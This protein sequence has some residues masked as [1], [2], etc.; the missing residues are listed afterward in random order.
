MRSSTTKLSGLYPLGIAAML[1]AA[2]L[3]ACSDQQPLAVTRAPVAGAPSHTIQAFDCAAS[4]TAR[5]VSCTP[6]GAGNG[7]AIIIGDQNTNIRLTSSNVSYDTQSET[8]QFDVTVQNLM[9]EAIG[10]PDG[11]VADSDGIQVFFNSGPTGVGTG[12]VTVANADGTGTFTATNQPFF[13]YHEILAKNQVSAAHP[14]QLTVPSTVTS[15]SFTLFVETDVQYLL[16]INEMLVNP[17][18]TI[19]DASG[20]WVELYNAG[21]LKVDLKGLVITDSLASG[22]R[23][24]HLIN[25]SVVVQ[26]GA[27]VVL[28]RTAN[29]TSNGGVP[30]DYVYTLNGFPNSLGAFKV[31]RVYGTDTLTVDRT[32]YASASTSAQNGISRELKNP[33]FDNS[34]MDGSNWGDATVIAVYGPGGRGTPKAQNSVFTP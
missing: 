15:F 8:F 28:G 21:T 24:Y 34:N 29:T 22:R 2:V 32:Q 4:T 31:A 19:T 10:T 33:A 11:V 3:V 16:V 17:G 1:G 18:G 23:P 6:R 9:N 27:Y 30:V 5:T 14:W 20:E 26:P 7:R 13:A 25:Q 12:E